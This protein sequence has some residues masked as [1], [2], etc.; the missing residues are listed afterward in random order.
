MIEQR[1]V[2]MLERARPLFDSGSA[3]VAVGAAHLGGPDGLLSA[4]HAAGYTV[5]RVPLE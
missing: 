4:L 1:N 5:T 3:L 2:R